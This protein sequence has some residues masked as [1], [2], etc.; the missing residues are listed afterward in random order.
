VH[1]QPLR[2]QTNVPSRQPPHVPPSSPQGEGEGALGVLRSTGAETGVT[3][4]R[5]VAETHPLPATVPLT[6]M[7][8]P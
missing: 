6:I 4:F 2:E 7:D 5:R 8:M 3:L 1:I